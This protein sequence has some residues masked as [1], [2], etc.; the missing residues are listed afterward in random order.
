MSREYVIILW[1]LLANN[2]LSLAVFFIGYNNIDS[3]NIVSFK[4]SS[5]ASLLFSRNSHN[6]IILYSH[7]EV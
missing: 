4:H 6:I 3:K 1:K 7:Y 5:K 2:M